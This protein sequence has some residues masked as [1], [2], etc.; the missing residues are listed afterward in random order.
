MRWYKQVNLGH[1]SWKARKL[2]HIHIP[3]MTSHNGVA[4]FGFLDLLSMLQL[5]TLSQHFPKVN[6]MCMARGCHFVARIH[7]IRM[8]I[9][10]ISE[11]DL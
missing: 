6:G 11:L 9:L 5:V 10:S 1:T 2:D 3:S 7:L 4:P 8:S